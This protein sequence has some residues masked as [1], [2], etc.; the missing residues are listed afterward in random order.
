[1]GIF[2][3]TA[4]VLRMILKTDLLI[5]T[6][7]AGLQLFM[8]DLTAVFWR[9]VQREVKKKESETREKK[10]REKEWQTWKIRKR[11]NKTEVR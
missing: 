5:W 4:K 3:N 6:Q 1:M 8:F 10:G 7:K 2:K 9:E 11:G